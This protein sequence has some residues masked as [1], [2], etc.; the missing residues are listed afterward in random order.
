MVFN[1][2]AKRLFMGG[3]T[4][5]VEKWGE[6]TRGG[7][8]G[9]NVLGGEMSCYRRKYILRNHDQLNLI[10][11]VFSL[12]MCFGYS[13]E[14]SHWDGSFVY[15]Q[16]RFWLRNKKII[17]SYALLSGGLDDSTFSR[18]RNNEPWRNHITL[19]VSNSSSLL[20]INS[21]SIKIKR[22]P[23]FWIAYVSFK[24]HNGI[25]IYR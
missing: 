19:Y 22:S 25:K 10:I 8:G 9:G 15:P 24:I 2:G 23:L 20:S 6:T 11:F 4:T 17:F 21:T 5:R 7:G 1:L 3:D 13:K 12:N 18:S 16:H 14:P